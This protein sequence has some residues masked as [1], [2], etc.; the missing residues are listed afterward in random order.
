MYIYVLHFHI[1]KLR[2]KE[3][4]KPKYFY[5]KLN[6]GNCGKVRKI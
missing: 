5:T 4:A 3:V 2:Y 1:R 6:K